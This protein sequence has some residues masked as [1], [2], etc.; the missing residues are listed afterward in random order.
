MLE[1]NVIEI[2]I[3]T[4]CIDWNQLIDLYAQTGLVGEYGNESPRRK[5][6]GIMS[7][8]LPNFGVRR[9]RRGIKP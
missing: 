9:K 8:G 3:G 5:H 2:K 1:V 6:R 4:N 7:T